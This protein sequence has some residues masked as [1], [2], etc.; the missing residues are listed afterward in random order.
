MAYNSEVIKI[1]L[2]AATYQELRELAAKVQDGSSQIQ[3]S[4][5]QLTGLEQKIKRSQE[6]LNKV[7]ATLT[8]MEGDMARR[9][10]KWSEVLHR[11]MRI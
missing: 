10:E 6:A 7:Q 8:T 2:E 5:L 9:E 3:G 1:E 11:G 4:T